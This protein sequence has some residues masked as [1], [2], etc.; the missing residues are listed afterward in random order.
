MA[1]LSVDSSAMPAIVLRQPDQLRYMDG[2]LDDA[3]R[4]MPVANWPGVMMIID[5]NGSP[6]PAGSRIFGVTRRLS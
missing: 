4:R 6:P 1:A 2:M 5:R 3:P